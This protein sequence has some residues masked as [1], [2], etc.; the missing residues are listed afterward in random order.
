MSDGPENPIGGGPTNSAPLRFLD[1]GRLQAYGY[2]LALIYGILFVYLYRLG[3]FIV[4]TTGGPAYADFTTMWVAGI[5][6]L[7]GEAAR[8]Y[9]STEFLS[10][11]RAIL[12]EKPYFYPNWPYPPIILLIAA[13]IGA[14]PYSVAFLGWNGTTLLAFLVVTYL[15]V[16][17]L[18]AI[19]VVLAWPFCAW[20]FGAGQ[21]G[22]VTGSLLGAALLCIERQPLLAGVFI[23]CLSYKPQFGIMLPVALIAARRWRVVISATATVAILAGLSIAA[24]GIESWEMLPTGLLTQKEV[25][26]FA[27]G[28][29]NPRLQ[30][31]YGLVRQLYGGALLAWALQAASALGL[32]VVVWRVWR[33]PV[34][35]SL[36]AATVSAATIA[37]TPY[38]F[39]YD[40]AALVIPAAFL[41]H[42]QLGHGFLKGEQTVILALFGAVLAAFVVFWV[43]GCELDFGTMPLGVPVVITLLALILR[44]AATVVVRVRWT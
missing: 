36:K 15:I 3:H 7:R 27:D 42:D 10:T 11:Q 5:E 1:A 19:P 29:P 12:G 26:L 33:S 21:N 20:N 25:V 35:H 30:T 6:A 37:A 17:R 41:V 22:F 2:T 13:P 4:D 9:D 31:V 14:L 44:R 39:S 28:D 18:P 24:F 8:L 34:R 16:R 23:G 40:M 43:S 38:A 32:A